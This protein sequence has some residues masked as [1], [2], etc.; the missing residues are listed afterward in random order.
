MRI[1][2]SY[3]ETILL[4]IENN[5][6]TSETLYN[7]NSD[8]LNYSHS[9][10]LNQNALIVYQYSKG[11]KYTSIISFF[12]NLSLVLF[13]KYYV[14]FVLCSLWGYYSALSYRPWIVLSYFIYTILNMTSRLSI[15]V[16][17]S[18][19]HYIDNDTLYGTVTLIWTILL[20]LSSIYTSILI[21]KMYTKLIICT[22]EEQYQLRAIRKLNLKALCW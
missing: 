7:L 4:D 8:N 1:G 13:N 20:T 6:D 11:M 22:Y 5:K 19:E 2:D 21:W 10:S 3:N 9:Q 18:I 15:N 16:Y 12:A 14:F 17:D